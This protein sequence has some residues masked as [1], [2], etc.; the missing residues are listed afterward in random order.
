MKK[1]C[2]FTATRAEYGLLKPVMEKIQD[3]ELLELQLMVGGTHLISEF[4]E[5]IS[6]IQEDGFE[7]DSKI[8]SYSKEDD[9]SSMVDAMGK[10]LVEANNE[11]ERI[12]SDL[13]VVLGDRFEILP[14]A[15]A[16]SY[17]GRALA[18]LSGGDKTSGY[19]EYTRHAVTK[20]AHIH[21]PENPNSK[22]RV[23][24]MGENPENVHKVGSTSIDAIK[25]K[26][27]KSRDYLKK[28]YDLDLDLPVFILIQHPLSTRPES[29]DEEIEATINAVDEF[30]AEVIG[31]YPN[32][33]P[34]GR[35][36]IEAI[37]GLT[38]ENP[39]FKWHRSLPF[40]DYISLLNICD[41][42]IGN[43]SSGIVESPTLKAPAVNIGPR[44]EN[45]TRAQNV[46][47]VSHDEEEI[48]AAIKKC[49]GDEEFLS[50]VENAQN[51]YG[52]G[53]ASEQIVEA[54]E[55]T[56]INENLLEKQIEY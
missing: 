22:E 38:E 9:K 13:V 17:S 30:D 44:Q 48:K 6:E 51:P 41:A 4:G 18:H 12:E 23:I 16:A 19:D 36:M 53:N 40:E 42:I 15:I 21:F 32:A 27:F 2:V 35:R 46:L 39:K 29:A 7:I 25:K 3:S 8:E 34:G 31:I 50:Q 43:S 28:K 52:D 33:D 37:N 14:V 54:L 10:I 1:V 56:E 47:D 5:T 49:L 45:R 26:N 55:E 24:K 20:L 11:L